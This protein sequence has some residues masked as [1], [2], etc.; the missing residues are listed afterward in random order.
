MYHFDICYQILK[1]NLP[2][3]TSTNI[4]GNCLFPKPGKYQV[5][6]SFEIFAIPIDEKHP[7][8]F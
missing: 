5:M 7:L 3:S 1:L 2:I 8:I 4:A 6:W